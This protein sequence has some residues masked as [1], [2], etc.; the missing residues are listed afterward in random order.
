MGSDRC[1]SSNCVLIRLARRPD[2]GA[3]YENRSLQF[4]GLYLPVEG[5]G[6][7]DLFPE[8]RSESR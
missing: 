5:A 2:G 8:E 7:E 4:S 6:L 1:R 3:R